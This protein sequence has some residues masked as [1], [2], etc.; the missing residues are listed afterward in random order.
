[1]LRYLSLLKSFFVTALI[2]NLEF[3]VNF[4]L[5]IFADVTWYIGQLLAFEVI[6]SHT[7]TI[8]GWN[9][10]HIRVFLGLLFLADS[11]FM[12]LFH[13]N[14]D[15]LSTKVKKGELDLLL[16]KPV[17]SQFM[18]SFSRLNPSYFINFIFALIWLIYCLS[19]IPDFN[20][21]R[22]FLLLLYIPSAVAIMD[23]LKF[24][25]ATA[26]VIFVSAESFLYLWFSL[27]RLGMR[28]DTIYVPWL[29]YIVLTIIP[30]GFLASVPARALLYDFDPIALIGVIFIP[31]LFFWISRKIWIYALRHYES[32]SS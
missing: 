16:V 15:N 11:I 8:A 19:N 21:T 20:W 12:T 24:M 27:Y 1:M 2:N 25:F 17:D 26:A 28:P 13:E 30:V 22:L 3:R 6:L 7:G 31:V 5:R 29:R 23:S 18:V 32:A 14:I 4:V 9:S 10:D